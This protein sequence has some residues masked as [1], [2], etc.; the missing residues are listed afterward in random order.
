MYKKNLQ[1]PAFKGTVAKECD[2]LDP[3]L[4]EADPHGELLPHEDVRVVGLPKTSLQLIQLAR[5]EPKRHS[6]VK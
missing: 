4:G 1:N 5:A 6:I 3:G 2:Y